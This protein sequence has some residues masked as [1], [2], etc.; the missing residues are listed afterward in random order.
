MLLVFVAPGIARAATAIGQID[1]G[2]PFSSCTGG[3]YWTQNATGAGVPSYSAPAD[4]VITSWSHKGGAQ[5]GRELGLRIFRLVSGT[6]YTLV[7]SSGVQI[8]TANTVN[9]FST[10]IP[11]K[12]G[13]RLGLYV[14]NPGFPIGGGTACT[15]TG[16]V[17]DLIH[18]GPANP[19]P[20][21][22][23]N[24]ALGMSYPNIYRLNVSAK[25]EPDAD[26]DGY[27]DETQDACPTS[28]V[29]VGACSAPD[30]SDRTPPRGTVKGKRDSVKD[31]F[32]SVKVTA[33]EP[34]TAVTTGTVSIPKTSRVYKLKGAK[35]SLGKNVAT[36]V[37]L[38]IPR[39][40]RR[41]I[42]RALR[43]HRQLK[44]K[45]TVVLS[46]AAGNATT[47]KSSVSLRR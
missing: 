41:P 40:A 4:G 17:S 20:A 46:D 39:E 31:R 1:S 22:G 6:T 42:A 18:E 9:T 5:A 14:G 43:R 16:G 47:L 33:D 11:V 21:V 12:A 30:A 37:K 7:G 8:V 44:A 3:S 34:V 19:E 26:G 38:L 23:T 10:R 36:K 2:T 28:A 35:R 29:S 45:L 15:S 25:V 13:D 27:G 24:L 32:V